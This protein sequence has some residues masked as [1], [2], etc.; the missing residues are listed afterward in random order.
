MKWFRRGLAMMLACMMLVMAVP[1]GGLAVY[2]AE[3]YPSIEVGGTAQAVIDEEY[4][5]FWFTPVESGWYQFYSMADSDTYGYVYDADGYTLE[6]DDDNGEG[7]NFRVVCQLEAGVTYKLGARFY[8]RGTGSFPVCIEHYSPRVI[9]DVVPHDLSFL[10]YQVEEDY[11]VGPKMDVYYSD[12]SSYN[13]NDYWISDDI[14]SYHVEY[15]YDVQPEEWQEGGVYTADY[16]IDVNGTV[17]EG[18]YTVTIEECPILSMEFEPIYLVEHTNGDWNRGD[19]WDSELGEYVHYEYFHYYD[20]YPRATVTMK[21]GT[22]YENVSE[23]HWGDGWYSFDFSQSYRNPLEYGMNY[24]TGSL[25]GYDYTIPVEVMDTP[26]ASIEFPTY[27]VIEE[28][29]GGW[30]SGNAWDEDLQQYVPYKYFRYDVYPRATVTLKDGTVYE[31]CSAFEWN[32]REYAINVSQSYDQ[33]LQVG[34]NYLS[35]TVLG[36]DYT[37]EVE[38]EPSPIASIVFEPCTVI[39]YSGGYWN[40]GE[41]WDY[42][43]QQYVPY[44][45]FHYQSLDLTYTVTMKDG[46]VYK[47]HVEWGGDWYNLGVSQNSDN[48]L[49][50]GTNYMTGTFMGY[51]YTVEIEVVESPVASVTVAPI[52]RLEYDNGYWVNDWYYDENDE[53]VDVEYF[54]Y[55]D[56][57]PSSSDEITILLKDGTVINDSSFEW[58]GQTYHLRYDGQW[59]QK[60]LT[61]G[62]NE[63]NGSIAGYDFTYIIEIVETPIV[64]VVVSPLSLV[65]E[66]DGY[67]RND[68]VWNPDLEVYEEVRWFYYYNENIRPRVTVTLNDGTVFENCRGFDWNGQY[69]SLS[70]D[71]QNGTR[72]LQFGQN[73]WHGSIAGYSFDYEIQISTLNSNDSYEYMESED[74][75]IITN[76]YLSDET[77]EIP[78]AINGKPVIGVTS[79]S[80]AW[81]TLKH[82]ILPDSVVTIGNYLLSNLENLESVHFGAGV[83]NLNAEMFGYCWGLQSITISEDNPYYCVVNNAL[84]N[85]TL[86]TFIAYPTANENLDYLVPATVV[87][88]DMLNWYDIYSRLNVIFPDDHIAYVTVDGVTYN[89]E[90]TVVI[91]CR[92]DKTGDYVM[93]ETVEEIATGAFMYSDLTS[94]VVSPKVTEIVYCAFASCANLETVILPEGLVSIDLH[95][96]EQTESL[97]EITLP[98]TLEYIGTYSFYKSGLTSLCVPDSVTDIDSSAFKESKIEVLDLGNGVQSIGESAFENT[99][100]GSVVLPDSLTYLDGSA[101][102]GCAALSSVTIGSGLHYLHGGVFA[103]TPSLRD[104]TIPDTVEWIEATFYN[105]GL[106]SVTL[107]EGIRNIAGYSFE[108]CDN[109]TA[110]H[111]PASAYYVSSTAFNGCDNL[112]TLTVAE[113]N[114]T[115]F[116]SGNCI[117]SYD[118]ELAV[119]CSTSFIPS[120]VTDIIYYSFQYCE[121]L[122]S[123]EI[124]FTVTSIWTDAFYGCDNLT[125]V[126]YQGTE[127]DRENIYIG[128]GNESLLNATWHY[129]WVNE[130][131]DEIPVCDHEYDSV[132]D[133]DCNLCGAR[134]KAPHAY[135]N[136]CAEWCSLCKEWREPSDH[137]Y[138]NAC[139]D[140]C[141]EC[142]G[143]RAVADHWYDN[144]C[145]AYCN[146]CGA[147]RE[148][149]DHW[150][151][152]ACDAD[153]NECGYIREAAAH[154]YDNKYDADCNECGAVRQAASPITLVVDNV[155]ARPGNTFNVAVRIQN[156]T[157]LVGFRFDVLYD[158]DQFELVGAVA[159]TNFAEATFGPVRSPFTVLWVDAIHPDNTANGVVVTLTFR[160][161]ENATLG[162]SIIEVVPYADDFFD[163]AYE[164]VRCEAVSGTVSVVNSTPGDANGDGKINVRDLGNIQQFLNGWDV[165]LDVTASDVNGDGKVNVRDLGLLQQYIN[166]WNVELK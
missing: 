52:T 154:V 77:V 133:S 48:Y 137:V 37:V 30:S 105:S 163:S 156:N 23:L 120:S 143:W 94:V 60:Y 104:I 80:S 51:D 138:D 87:N 21:D 126:Y 20:V 68:S 88:I 141:N 74:Y 25:L 3:S 130:A 109:L 71:S 32:G 157:G 99:P 50:L 128:Q 33:Q 15:E 10:M 16:R 92:K 112:T 73:I 103:H 53:R 82:L 117:I 11:Y 155:N 26:I 13:Y 145:D 144:A 98:D 110:V 123:I 85:K 102:Y 22:V 14:G 122:T 64:S 72:H 28:H 135:E 118:G 42:N 1:F 8:G 38:V 148:T 55:N 61:R 136:A 142:G 18:Q 58:N 86:D 108:N 44:K 24:V 121:T 67:W 159:G 81:V 57:S 96:F 69:Y 140:T 49:T 150:Y 124:P 147:W 100:V 162:N 152:N 9:T 39:E 84:H 149:A 166:G 93:P 7:S 66:Q 158:T 75:V 79:L 111:I 40:E 161:S 132:C 12:G 153:C 90:M 97:Q 65:E 89:K 125:D 34:T 43:L 5:Y 107:S 45:Y 47:D 83:S 41:D 17:Y 70:V 151:D 35:G 63:W 119:G 106:E 19:Y 127:A 4:A 115:Y 134:R 101:F 56:I 113:G 139:D 131:W 95:A 91:S 62:V 2:A 78:A 36:Y 29:N 6:S 129:N 59:A 165:E 146:E 160:V 76:C 54:H 31:D 27:S 116:S 114:E 164:E 46:S